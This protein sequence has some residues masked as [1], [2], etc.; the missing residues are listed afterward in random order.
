MKLILNFEISHL[1]ALCTVLY[2]F[3]AYYGYGSNTFALILALLL[4]IYIYIKRGY[5]EFVH[6]MPM[7]C[8]IAYYC[9]TR[10]ACNI[11][12]LREMVAPSI[13][14][15]FL[16]SGLFNREIQLFSFLKLYKIMAIVNIIFFAVQEILYYILG[17]RII[18]ILTFFPLT[19]GGADFNSSEYKVGAME[20]ERSSA[21]FSEPAHFVQF[22]LPL[23]VIELFY[24]SDRKSYVRCA[25]YL[26]TLLALASGNALLGL[27]V[28]ALFFIADLLQKL[29]KIV[30]I[31]AIGLFV[32][33]SFFSIN[34]I[35]TTEYGE[36]LLARSSQIESD[37]K[38][39]SSGFERIY[40]GY[41]VW[42]ELTPVEK[43]IWINSNSKVKEKIKKCAVTVT[44]GE[45]DTYMN[46]VQTFLIYTGYIGTALFC[47]LLISL[48]RGNNLAG[49]CCIVIYVSL[50]F[51]ASVFYAYIMVLYLLVAFLMKKECSKTKVRILKI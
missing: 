36:K 30:A 21:F 35:L 39:Y 47:W 4:F 2:P 40:R 42:E 41:Y 5:L 33:I 6:P 37:A 32:V 18:G 34:Y 14:Y 23:L 9:V 12:S 25:V 1:V 44:F 22:L 38:Q 48:W 31:M 24:V 45:G 15:I 27:C 3:L 20:A 7:F 8:F 13:L 43:W 16:L 19:I 29:K 28:I 51:I 50:C 11:S 26:L 49:R 10:V 46:A 17:Y